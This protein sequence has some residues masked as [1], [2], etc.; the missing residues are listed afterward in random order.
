MATASL[1]AQAVENSSA[2][3]ALDRLHQYFS[4]TTS[5]PPAPWNLKTLG[6][7]LALVVIWAMWLYGTWAAGET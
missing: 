4:R 6:G 5:C 2:A 3:G 1:P 7:L